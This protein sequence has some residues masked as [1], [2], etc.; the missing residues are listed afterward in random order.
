[1][2]IGRNWINWEL[3]EGVQLIRLNP[4]RYL[5]TL[6]AKGKVPYHLTYLR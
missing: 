5:H 4:R 6:I 1:M 2:E 3:A